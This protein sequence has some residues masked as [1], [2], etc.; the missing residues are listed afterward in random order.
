MYLS[1]FFRSQCQGDPPGRRLLPDK[2]LLE[3]PAGPHLGLLMLLANRFPLAL[4]PP[5][6]V[7][8]QDE[9]ARLLLYHGGLNPF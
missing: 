4:A 7:R 6:Q 5:R 8:C 3:W 1:K 2:C 9:S